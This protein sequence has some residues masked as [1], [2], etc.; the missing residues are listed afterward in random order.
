MINIAI[1]EDDPFYI[2]RL[3]KLCEGYRESIDLNID[4]YMSGEELIEYCENSS[5]K[6]DIAFLDIEMKQINGLETAKYLK[7]KNINAIVIFIS[8]YTNYITNTF[9]IGAF[10]FLIKPFKESDFNEDFKRAIEKYREVHA[11]YIIKFSGETSVVEYKEIKYIEGYKRHLMVYTEDASYECVG[12]INSEAEKFKIYRFIRC[13][14]G[15]MVNF[16]Y[17]REINKNNIVLKNGEE[18]PMSRRYRE[19]VMNTFNLYLADTL[20]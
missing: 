6:Y 18:I 11:N 17:I 7:A 8:G 1:C 20:T 14:Q 15:Y 13:H 2:D 19:Q 10:Q 16:S 5:I 9:R 3:E 12:S 4:K